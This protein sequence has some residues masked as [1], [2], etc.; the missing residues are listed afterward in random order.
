MCPSFPFPEPKI[1]ANSCLQ[2][3]RIK[4][5]AQSG[6][7]KI[8]LQSNETVDMFCDM[9]TDS[10]GWTLVWVYTFTQYSQF[11]DRSN[12]VTPIPDWPASDANVA[13][14]RIPPLNESS[15]GALKFSQWKLLGNDFLIKSSINHWISCTSGTGSLVEWIAGSIQCKNVR[16]ITSVCP[17]TAPDTIQTDNPKGPLLK[18]SSEDRYYF[19]DGDTTKSTP[20]HD[21]CGRGEYNQKNGVTKPR[22]GLFIR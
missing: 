20:I 11:S 14:S 17:G 9:E 22:G 16:N 10:G 7:F 13:Y 8:N 21:P 1:Y 6:V 2:I 19:F 18:I 5:D 15:V 12:A 4:P 3:K